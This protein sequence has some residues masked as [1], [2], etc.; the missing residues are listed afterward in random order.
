MQLR[1]DPRPYWLS[2]KRGSTTVDGSGGSRCGLSPVQGTVSSGPPVWSSLLVGGPVETRPVH[3]ETTHC[4]SPEGLG[5]TDLA[6]MSRPTLSGS[7]RGRLYVSTCDP[8]G[9]RL[10]VERV[11]FK[12]STSHDRLSVPVPSGSR[13]GDEEL[14]PLERPREFTVWSENIV[15]FPET[16]WDTEKD[17]E[18]T[19]EGKSFPTVWAAIVRA[20]EGRPSFLGFL[21]TSSQKRQRRK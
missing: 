18:G 14:G 17:P 21:L 20:I 3:G 13:C 11:S 6:L 1:K 16:P 9:R 2:N 8:T 12:I 7:D 10:W 4:W 19:T 5:Q 15:G